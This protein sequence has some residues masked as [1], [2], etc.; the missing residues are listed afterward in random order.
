MRVHRI[1]LA[2]TVNGAP[3]QRE[4]AG[5]EAPVTLKVVVR[6]ALDND[7]ITAL[8]QLYELAPLHN[9]PALGRSPFGP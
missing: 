2:R 6:H 5:Q 8:I 1:G 9:E 4:E 3:I 7:V